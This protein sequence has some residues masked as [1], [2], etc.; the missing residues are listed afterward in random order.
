[1][2]IAQNSVDR[3]VSALASAQN[4]LRDVTETMADYTVVAP[5]DG[6]A[7]KVSTQRFADAASGSAVVTLITTQQVATI[8][9]NEVDVAKI[10]V[11]QKATLKF[12]AIDGLSIAGEV[13]EVSP[14]GTASQGVVNYDV[15]IAFDSQDDRVKIGMSVSVSIVTDVKADVLA[16]ANSAVKSLGDQHYVETLDATSSTKAGSDGLITTSA[17]PKRV[18]VQTGVSNESLTEIIDGLKEGDSVIVQTVK[19]SST[20]TSTT[21]NSSALRI[22]GVGGGNA[23]FR[24]S[25]GGMARPD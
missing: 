8:S 22:P 16:V 14:L 9:L 13:A 2:Q 25:A 15:K 18:F 6:V 4:K 5:F 23:T 24:T 10:K 12:D 3:S 17:T 7:G 11:G 19:S 20:K 1:M 21:Q